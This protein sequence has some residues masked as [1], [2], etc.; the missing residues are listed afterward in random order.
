MECKTEPAILGTA[1]SLLTP[2]EVKREYGSYEDENG[3]N[4]KNGEDDF[5]M[6]NELLQELSSDLTS[7]AYVCIFPGCDLSFNRETSYKKHLYCHAV[8]S[9]GEDSDDDDEDKNIYESAYDDDTDDD[10]DYKDDNE[11]NCDECGKFFASEDGLQRHINKA[12]GDGKVLKCDKCSRVFQYKKALIKHVD[13]HNGD[14]MKACKCKLCPKTFSSKNYL[15]KHMTSHT[16]EKPYPCTHCDKAYT[17]N[18]NLKAHMRFHSGDY[19]HVCN[20]CGK[21]FTLLEDQKFIKHVENHKRVKPN[22][23]AHCPK[24]FKDKYGLGLHM[25]V[26]TGEKPWKCSLCQKGFQTKQNYEKHQ[27]RTH[28][29]FPVRATSEV[30]AMNV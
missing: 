20:L 8:K 25:R 13:V 17:T 24:A 1:K 18:D 6:A 27:Q 9:A 21:R 19:P 10:A 11:Y 15:S 29:I 2:E 5:S 12:H 22:Q 30:H 3:D 16:G 26:H 7:K 23:C 4:S 14:C 28:G